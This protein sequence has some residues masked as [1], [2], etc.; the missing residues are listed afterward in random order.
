VVAVVVPVAVAVVVPV[1]VPV[2][3]AV[4]VVVAVAVAVAVAARGPPDPVARESCRRASTGRARA[5]RGATIPAVDAAAA[6]RALARIARE[7]GDAD[8]ATAVGH[9][10]RDPFAVLVATV[11]ST[12]TRDPVT[13]AAAGRL[14]ALA[15]SA[16]ALA[17]LPLS[18]I[19]RAVFPVGFWRT[20]ARALRA[21]AAV[22][23]DRFGG[24]VPADLDLLCELPGVGR[25]V[26]SLVLVLGHGIPA[27]CVDIHVHRIVNR[28]GFVRTRTPAGT[29]AALRARLPRR[30]WLAVNGL[31]VRW[32]QTVCRP[33]HPRCDACAVSARCER[34]AVGLAPGRPSAR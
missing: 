19:E 20:K 16:D 3:V 31:L 25:K 12:R 23:R 2:A 28:W 10:R 27:V 29:E 22:L 14:L 1:P 9:H 32:G 18:T 33:R 17:E 24:R 30:W 21:T 13:D 6:S 4:A 26:A 8:A 15:P 5:G 34:V 11:L 7:L